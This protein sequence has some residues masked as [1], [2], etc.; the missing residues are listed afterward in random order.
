MVKLDNK[1]HAIYVL[2]FFKSSVYR[3]VC[4]N[5]QVPLT[6]LLKHSTLLC[7][8]IPHAIYPTLCNIEIV[9]L[10]IIIVDTYLANAY[11]LVD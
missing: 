5:H 1:V 4:H 2:T 10:R 7:P 11:L 8:Q 9:D 6:A 3:I